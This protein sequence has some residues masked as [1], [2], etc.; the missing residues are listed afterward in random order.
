MPKAKKPRDPRQ[1]Y[2][3]ISDSGVLSAHGLK[4]DAI[5]SV[6]EWIEVDQRNCRVKGPYVLAERTGNR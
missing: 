4:R 1:V 3:V 2:L 6:D 5:E